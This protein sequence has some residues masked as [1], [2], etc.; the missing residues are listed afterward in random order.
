MAFASKKHL[1]NGKI[2][3]SVTPVQLKLHAQK[4]VFD[5]SNIKSYAPS[6]T[7]KSKKKK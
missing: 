6:K 1:K 2:V 4:T 5:P 7:R 3:G